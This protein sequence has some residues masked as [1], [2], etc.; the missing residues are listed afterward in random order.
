M[1]SVITP[2]LNML[3]YLK[4]CTLS[5]Q[6]QQQVDLE[7]IVVDG[8]STDGTQEWL[9]RNPQVRSIREPDLGMYD[10]I[11]KG[12][13]LSRGHILG[14]LNCDE[15]YLP[16]TLH[17]VQGYFDSHAA[18]DMIFGHALL[19]RPDGSLIAYRKSYQPRRIYILASHLYLLTCG[20]F[21]RKRIVDEG[22]FMDPDYRIIGD[23]EF[24][25]R[26]LKN[27]YNV[28]HVDRYLSAYTMTGQ[29]LST[30]GKV[31]LEQKKL[32]GQTSAWVPKMR[33]IL[34]LARW[35]EKFFSGA[36]FQ[37]M[38]LE[39]AVYADAGVNRRTKH[40]VHRASFR[41]RNSPPD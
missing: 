29:N 33:Y 40:T 12:F 25:L 22:L 21:F 9:K 31:L 20:M 27:G 15:Q 30:D 5:I 14:W 34:N 41:W 10:A 1:I 26:V 23:R 6:D 13:R 18:V 37:K 4:R 7:H 17:W 16:D 36:Y 19:I 2:S 39:Y 35:M 28:Q 24:V 11:N 32:I 38:P 3:D 8:A